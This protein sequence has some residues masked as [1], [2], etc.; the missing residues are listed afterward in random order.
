MRLTL[1]GLPW[2]RLTLVGLPWVGVAGIGL[3][4]VV[5]AW[6][7]LVWVG[8]YGL[9]LG[10]LPRRELRRGVGRAGRWGEA[11]VLR[12]VWLV[13]NATSWTGA[14]SGTGFQRLWPV[15]ARR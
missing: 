7:G 11:L 4:R 1:V 14:G 6:V 15:R 5:L 2:V 12:V 10:E 9:G 8:L 3:C 13:H